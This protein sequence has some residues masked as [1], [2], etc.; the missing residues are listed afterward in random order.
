V[1]SP[2]RDTANSTA[3]IDLTSNRAYLLP[4]NLLVSWP[5]RNWRR[6]WRCEDKVDPKL[7]NPT[8]CEKLAGQG[9]KMVKGSALE[10]PPHGAGLDTS[11]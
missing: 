8:V 6:H 2:F 10:R 3:F 5:L 4:A 9:T 7:S 1:K 11:T